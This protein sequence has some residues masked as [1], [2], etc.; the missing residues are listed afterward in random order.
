MAS[1]G[2]GKY[3]ERKTR[4]SKPY[5]RPKGII[6]RVTDSFTG[7]FSA[8][9]LSGWMGG[10]E[11]EESGDPQ[12]GPS[13]A[14][15]HAPPGESFIFAHPITARRSFRPFYPEEGE[16]ESNSQPTLGVNEGASTSSGVRTQP[17]GG[18]STS[19]RSVQLNKES[20]GSSLSGRRLPIISST[21]ATMFT[22]RPKGQME[23]RPL[24]LLT[25]STPACDD[26]SE[27]SE[28]SA[29]TG[30]DASVIPR[31]DERDYQREILQL[32]EESLQTLRDSL[33]KPVPASP[34]AQPAT[35]LPSLE[36][37]RKRPRDLEPDHSSIRAEGSVSSKSLFSESGSVSHGQPQPSALASKRPRF[38]VSIYGSPVMSDRS[39]L[40]DST[41]K[42]SPFYPGKTMYGGASAYRSRRLPVRSSHQ[43]PR[44]QV[45]AKPAPQ[46]ADDGGLSQA[47][48]RI[49]E[50]LEQMSTPISDA[51][52]IPTPTPGHRGSFLDSS[53]TAAFH[54]HRPPTRPSAPPSSKLLTPSK[55]AVQENLSGSLLPSTSYLQDSSIHKKSTGTTTKKEEACQTVSEFKSTEQK[56]EKKTIGVSSENSVVSLFS[57]AAAES[58]TKFMPSSQPPASVTSS[59]PPQDVF[60]FGVSTS[61]SASTTFEFTPKPSSTTF[62]SEISPSSK[63][64]G[65]MKTKLIDSGR[66]SIRREEEVMEEPS[67]T[68]VPLPLPSLPKINLTVSSAGQGLQTNFGS[69]PEGFKFSIPEVVDVHSTSETLDNAPNFTFRNPTLIGEGSTPRPKAVMPTQPQ[70]MFNSSSSSLLVPKLKTNSK[71]DVT[72]E[73]LKGGSILDILKP[74]RKP[75]N[76]SL[77]VSPSNGE[78]TVVTS[79]EFSLTN[80]ESTKSVLEQ[81]VNS[82]VKK[83]DTV[84]GVQG[85]GSMFKKSS[86]EWECSVCMLRNQNTSVKCVA[87][88]AQRPGQT[89]SAPSKDPVGA[90]KSSA[91]W[92][93]SGSAWGD[94]FK[95]SASEWDCDTCMVRNKDSVSKCVACE[96]P[97]PGSKSEPKGVPDM[98]VDTREK[99]NT[100]GFGSAFAKQKGEWECDTCL[101][102]NKSDAT[103]CISCETPKPGA[104]NVSEAITGNFKFG[105]NA[106]SNDSSTVGSTFK[107]GLSNSQTEEKAASSGFNFGV[108]AK[109][110]QEKDN[111]GNSG[112]K[113]GVPAEKPNAF[114]VHSFG[115]STESGQPKD[116]VASSSVAFSFGV[117]K[118]DTKDKNKTEATGEPLLFGSKTSDGVESVTSTTPAFQFSTG[119]KTHVAFSFDSGTQDKTK[120]EQKINASAAEA[121]PSLSEEVKSSKTNELFDAKIGGNEGNTNKP[122]FTF[123]S[124]TTNKEDDSNSTV[125]ASPFGVLSKRDPPTVV[126]STAPPAAT[127]A[128]ALTAP[129]GATSGANTTPSGTG[130][131]FGDK[132]SNPNA[133]PSFSFSHQPPA[134]K[135]ENKPTLAFSF[136]SKIDSSENSEPAKK[137]SFASPSFTPTIN[138]GVSAPSS[139]F[140]FGSKE[141][142]L[143][144]GSGFGTPPSS[145]PAF[146]APAPS[147]NA[148]PAFQFGNSN[149]PARAAT[150]PS[151]FGSP[152][153]AFGS[154]VNS[155]NSGFAFGQPTEKKSSTGFDF[156]QAASNT[157]PS[158]FNFTAAV[159]Q[160]ST[161]GLFQFGQGQ[162]N[163]SSPGGVFQFGSRN[164]EVQ[165]PGTTFG[166]NENPFPPVPP[167][168]RLMKKAI[169]RTKK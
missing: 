65:K 151:A 110:I 152:A 23:P 115:S 146:G 35:T 71:K 119:T 168:G 17:P 63:R 59:N 143:G 33:T 21:P 106:T 108:G 144:S 74:K 121:K 149:A 86:D 6:R 133:F 48:R 158:S 45:K 134:S 96:T 136:G 25:T 2:P 116:K 36:E 34:I 72:P 40:S 103:K 51:K 41:F 98:T 82:V 101:V 32:D 84:Q 16:T 92:G 27:V 54:R 62:T 39:V 15:T 90:A 68:P 109:S 138:N 95:K 167:S 4:A 56:E 53:Y 83:T 5:E 124:I 57:K 141:S 166:N 122:L 127:S 3:R 1:D 156:G 75:E 61:S 125:T 159:P 73:K 163:N 81:P 99:T 77:T 89:A 29:D 42:A 145:T 20:S 150:A 12:P 147:S 100:L 169:R 128:A 44:A 112:F 8:S 66:S 148:T 22:S 19:S 137:L 153:P 102:R 130:F 154:S 30:V 9:W 13:Q 113:F 114:T 120:E 70:L 49:L 91:S 76:S 105:V 14:S 107:F 80:S 104:A 69:L 111:Q 165:A 162:T 46:S 38:N 11:E 131:A 93:G 52:R 161:P 85:F 97:K 140:T 60:N 47:A 64:V 50:S 118:T 94:A 26:G 157:G 139:L 155:S 28:S 142:K 37:T 88:E 160:S 87:C 129:F 123:N 24:P 31:P 79:K 58:T 117:Q 7:L 18:I 78:K 67:I 55:V 126:A 132:A 164:S 43:P 135:E 10:E